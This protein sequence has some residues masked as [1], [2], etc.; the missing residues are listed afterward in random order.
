MKREEEIKAMYERNIDML[1]RICY[2]Y[3]HGNTSMIDDPIQ[4]IFLKIIEKKI[5]FHDLNHEKAW[6]IRAIK[7]ECL[8]IL[9]RKDNNNLELDIDIA[10]YD[11]SD[12][13]L[14]Y[15]LRLPEK[16]KMPIYLYYYE[17]YSAKEISKVL[18][19]SENTVFSQL[20]RGRELLKIDLESD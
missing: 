5:T 17:G 13:I 12:S 19:E 14:E 1:F 8:N 16:Y 2:Q 15:V 20:C 18:D 6:M 9:K 10:T 7:N 3:F 4:N 11:G